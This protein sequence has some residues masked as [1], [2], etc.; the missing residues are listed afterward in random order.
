MWTRDR[1]GRWCLIA[2]QCRYL[3]QWLSGTLSLVDTLYLCPHAVQ[4]DRTQDTRITSAMGTDCSITETPRRC[5]LLSPTRT[6]L[7]TSLSDKVPSASLEPELDR[8]SYVTKSRP[9]LF[10]HVG[11]VVVVSFFLSFERRREER[12]LFISKLPCI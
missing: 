3:L 10:L 7:R 2:C 5:L 9:P 4:S 11:F 6:L 12:T 1:G 8:E